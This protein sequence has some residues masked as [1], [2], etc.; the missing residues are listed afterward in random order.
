MGEHT[1]YLFF[2]VCRKNIYVGIFRYSWINWFFSLVRAYVLFFYTS[3][4]T[5]LYSSFNLYVHEYVY[6]AVA[7]YERNKWTERVD[8]SLFQPIRTKQIVTDSIVMN[9]LIWFERKEQGKSAP[10][11]GSG[12]PLFSYRFASIRHH[13]CMPSIRK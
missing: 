2:W 10:V 12:L 7:L 6:F 11:E 13:R 1:S 5:L 3:T 9:V 4:R 8:V